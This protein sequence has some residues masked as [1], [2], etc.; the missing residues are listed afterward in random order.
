MA[1]TI[2]PFGRTRAGE[3]VL[4]G[5]I[6]NAAGMAVTVLDYGATIQSVCVPDGRGGRVDVALGY[7]TVA[8]YEA[9]D[10]Y[11]GAT[12]GRVGNRIGGARFSLNGEEYDL[13]KNDGENHLHGGLRGFD[14]YV[15]DMKAGLLPDLPGRG[16]GV[17]RDA[18][19][20]GDV[21]PLGGRRPSHHL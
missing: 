16:G 11:L 14:K 6:E 9:G 3:E 5:R 8:G 4:A 20:D 19:G 21:H 10:G 18:G 17:S 15:W 12:I 7:D 13:A 2:V 1:V